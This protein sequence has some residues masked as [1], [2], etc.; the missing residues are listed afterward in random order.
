MLVTRVMPF[1]WL[2]ASCGAAIRWENVASAMYIQ[3]FYLLK[4]MADLCRWLRNHPGQSCIREA[5]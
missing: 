5:L 3:G 1:K 4:I 2:P